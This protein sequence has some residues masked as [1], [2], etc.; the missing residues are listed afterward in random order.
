MNVTKISNVVEVI[1]AIIGRDFSEVKE[2]L[3]AVRDFTTW[4]Q[5]DVVDGK[6]AEPESWKN[7]LD[8]WEP[9]ELPKKIGLHLMVQY[10]EKVIADWMN[11]PADRI[12]IHYESEGDKHDMI[13]KIK[14]KGPQSCLVLNLETDISVIDPYIKALDVVQLMSIAKIGDYG[15]PFC[16]KVYEK[17]RA[18][19]AKYPSVT[20]QVDGGVNMENAKGLIDS[21]VNNLVIGSA[22]F[23]SDNIEKAIKEFK[24]LTQ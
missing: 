3:D 11:S 4:V 6:F 19:R 24:K 18:L 15:E 8:L 1:P 21:G 22:I 23:K 13:K 2:K 9:L 16:E 7:P 5:L 10:P 20:I 14:D 17:I 12:C